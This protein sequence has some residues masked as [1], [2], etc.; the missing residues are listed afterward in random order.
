MKYCQSSLFIAFPWLI[1]VKTLC[2]FIKCMYR[3]INSAL[4][5]TIIYCFSMLV[6]FLVITFRVHMIIIYPCFPYLVCI[7]LTLKFHLFTGKVTTTVTWLN[8]ALELKRSLR[9]TNHSWP[10]RC[11]TRTQVQTYFWF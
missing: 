8:L 7:C 11:E 3:L 10:I 1:R 2:S 9:L 5:L 6:Y 4:L